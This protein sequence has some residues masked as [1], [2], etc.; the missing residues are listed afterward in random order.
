MSK[1]L[2]HFV[3][4]TIFAAF[5]LQFGEFF[6]GKLEKL[7]ENFHI[8]DKKNKEIFLCVYKFTASRPSEIYANFIEFA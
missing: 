8:G 6:C 4:F 3:Y 7:R 2:K 5:L 1:M